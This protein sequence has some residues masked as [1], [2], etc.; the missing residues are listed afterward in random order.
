MGGRKELPQGS[1]TRD[2]HPA[3][4]FCEAPPS[5]LASWALG[6]AVLRTTMMSRTRSGA[7]GSGRSGSWG[8]PSSPMLKWTSGCRGC[9]WWQPLPGEVPGP[10]VSRQGCHS[11]L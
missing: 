4:K 11:P 9:P 2:W 6:L 8:K 5:T 10:K 7:R 1:L 3:F